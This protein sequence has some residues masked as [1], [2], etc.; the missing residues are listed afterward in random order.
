MTV[1]LC[2]DGLEGILCGV[3]DAFMSRKGHANVKLVLKSSEDTMELF[4]QY[5][6]SPVEEEKVQKVIRAIRSKISEEAYEAVYKAALSRDKDRADRI[7]RFLICG[8]HAG[9]GIVDMLQLEEV[10]AIF[11]MC[12]FINNETHLL[13]E[14]VRFVDMEEGLLVGKIGP[15]NDVLVLLAPHFADRMSGENWIIYDERRKKAVFHP[16]GKQWFV[17]DLVSEEWEKRLKKA[18]EEDE[19]QMLYKCFRK[20]ICIKERINPRCQMNHM[21]LRYRPYMPEYSKSLR[22]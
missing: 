10:F 9:P 13:T 2:E 4:C 14:F 3:Y 11:E 6:E 16:A 5:E 18:S 1:Y 19:Y 20:S 17:A 15:K 22:D 8:F 7:Y 21:P 12:R